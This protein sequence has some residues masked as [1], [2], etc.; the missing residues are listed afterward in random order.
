[1]SSTQKIIYLSFFSLILITSFFAIFKLTQQNKTYSRSSPQST[2]LK[3]QNI[4]WE[5][6]ELF[7]SECQIKSIFQKRDFSVT[8]RTKDNQIYQTTQ[9]KMNDIINLAKKYQ[10]PCDIIQMITE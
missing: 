7:M 6:V 9:N 3:T 1:M 8:L 4:N 10:G 2:P 5:Q